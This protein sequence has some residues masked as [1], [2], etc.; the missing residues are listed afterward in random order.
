MAE[1]SL[2]AMM[3]QFR[4]G[5]SCAPWGDVIGG[6]AIMA[7]SM[8]WMDIILLTFFWA[9]LSFVNQTLS[10]V[11][12]SL[13]EAVSEKEEGKRQQSKGGAREGSFGNSVVSQVS[14]L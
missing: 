9:F 11:E 14:T 13:G 10:G 6:F 3:S 7:T 1:S 2:V 5:S 4:A 8:I 12:G